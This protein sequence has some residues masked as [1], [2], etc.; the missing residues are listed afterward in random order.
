VARSMI[1]GPSM[2]SLGEFASSSGTV[3][4]QSSIVRSA[5]YAI[6]ANPT[7]GQSSITITPRPAGGGTRTFAMSCRFYLRVAALPSG[8]ACR[9]YTADESV[10]LNTNGTLTA[11]G[12]SASSQALSVDGLWHRI[13]VNGNSN[14]DA[15]GMEVY[16]DGV[17][18]SS[19]SGATFPATP[20]S[21]QIGAF[22]NNTT[23]DLYFSDLLFDDASFSTTG[24]PG[25]GL[26][27][28]LLPTADPGAL[29]SWTNGGGGT[30]SI[31]EG[32]NNIPPTGAA[33]S[34]NGIKIKN[35]ASGGNLD[36][37]PTMQTYLAAGIPVGSR[38]N[39]VMAI[40]NDGEEVATATKAGGVWV[41]SN[42]AQGAGGNSFDYGDDGG[43]LGTFP[44]GWKTHVGPVTSN[45]SVTLSTAPT[46]TV[47]KT[48]STTRVVDVD[49]MGIYV[50]YSPPPSPK[51]TFINQS[52]RRASFY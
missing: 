19:D 27:K 3:S 47:R 23:A 6:R 43:A 40:C 24:L 31:F 28:L 48:T 41:A 7:A 25:D 4:V 20:A 14:L 46:M 34:T 37:T 17:L 33:A 26:V 9:I 51:G 39:A 42:P 44:T 52:V 21:V 8:S 38:I 11:G 2:G 49:F 16:V 36:Y 30:T 35:A 45:P 22:F 1:V 18:W 10:T 32:V 5:S 12:G 13:E 50:D 15:T 29:N